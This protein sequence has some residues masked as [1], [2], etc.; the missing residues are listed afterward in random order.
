MANW[1]EFY[2]KIVGTKENC[3]LF[4]RILQGKHERCFHRVFN[5]WVEW[6]DQCTNHYHMEL[7]G[8]CAWSV[9]CAMNHEMSY[10]DGPD[11]VTLQG[12]SAE[13]CLEIEVYSKEP[14]VGFAEHYCFVNGEVRADECVDY[15]EVYW[16]K[17]EH[18][19]IAELNA[20]YGTNYSEA[21]FDDEGFFREGGFDD[22]CCLAA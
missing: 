8:N 14:C 22:R 12:L 20:E 6:E 16:D 10:S 13:L 11:S 2:I 4:E 15:T 17:D 5:A 1:C 9:T 18:P 7:A 19:T 21:D 3:K